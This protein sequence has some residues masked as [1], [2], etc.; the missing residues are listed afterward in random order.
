MKNLETKMNKIST[1]TAETRNFVYIYIYTFVVLK[2]QKNHITIM[3]FYKSVL[4]R[5]IPSRKFPSICDA[6]KWKEVREN[7]RKKL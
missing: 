4:R 6:K 1:K 5:E 2:E 3:S 7:D